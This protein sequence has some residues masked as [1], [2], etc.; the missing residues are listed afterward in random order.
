T[1]I[2]TPQS[3]KNIRIKDGYKITELE[4]GSEIHSKAIVISTGV[5]YKKLDI[6]GLEKFSG[7]GVYYGAAS[8]EA[9]ACRDETIFIV[10]GG[11]SA[12]QAAMYISKFA[13]EV[14]ILIRRD[15]L[16]QV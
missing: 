15:E 9:Q 3:V 10:G 12:C 14:N 16:R 13:K 11:N 4:D 6:P 8:L 7:A 1:E 2:L 5:S